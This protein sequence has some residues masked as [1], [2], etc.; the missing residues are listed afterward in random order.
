MKHI[1]AGFAQVGSCG[2]AQE[3]EWRSRGLLFLV[4]HA[5]FARDGRPGRPAFAS[6]DSGAHAFA[7]N[8]AVDKWPTS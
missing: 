3:E 1:H 5:G 6:A 8:F 2:E 7:V 4:L